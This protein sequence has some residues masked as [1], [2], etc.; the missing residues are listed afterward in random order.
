M[1]DEGAALIDV[2]GESTRPGSQ[3]VTAKEQI[4]RVV[5]VIKALKQQTHV[6]IS[7]DTCDVNVARAAL[8]AGAAMI[9][10]ISALADEAMAEL[11]STAQVPVVLM[12]MQGTPGTMQ[13]DPA[14]GD[15]VT[16]VIDFLTERAEKAEHFGIPRHLVFLDPGIGFGKTLVHN[17]TL[18]RHLDR[19]TATGFR[20]LIGPSRKRFLGDLCQRIEPRDRVFGTAATV[21]YCVE[22]GAAVLRVHDVGAMVDVIKTVTAIRRGKVGHPV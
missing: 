8:E 5:P 20:V 13:E 22:H 21:A 18:L 14:Y 2:G 16:E 19:L 15:V 4:L 6:P 12:H 1:A 9:N 7:I 3:P 17:L 10:D 11:A